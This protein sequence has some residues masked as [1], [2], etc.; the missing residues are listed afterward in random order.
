MLKYM[1]K[2]LNLYGKYEH[3]MQNDFILKNDIFYANS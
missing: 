2:R 1:L 3:D